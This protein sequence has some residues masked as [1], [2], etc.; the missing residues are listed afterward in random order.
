MQVTNYLFQNLNC[1]TH[2]FYRSF[3]L[4][5]NGMDLE[6]EL[7]LQFANAQ[8][9]NAVGL[10]HQSVNIQ[11]LRGKI[12]DPVLFYDMVELTD[13]E[14]LILHPVDVVEPAFGNAP[15]DRHLTAFMRHL[16]LITGPA[17]STLVTFRRCPPLAGGFTAAK[18]LLFMRCAFSR[19][20]RV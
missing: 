18:P 7:R 20:D 19:L 12:G 3:G 11:I 15:L 14:D 16:A 6:T 2:A 13:V 9:L 10:A 17:L 5:A 1:P 8:D 4:T